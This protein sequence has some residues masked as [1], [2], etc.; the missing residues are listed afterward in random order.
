MKIA[1]KFL[2]ILIV[3][4]C[5][6]TA[7]A[8]DAMSFDGDLPVFKWVQLKSFPEMRVPIYKSEGTIGPGVLF[9]HG[10]SSS[11]RAFHKQIYSQFGRKYKMFFMD[12]PGHGLASKVDLSEAMPTLPNS[13][14]PA[15]FKAYQEGVPEAVGLVANDPDVQAKVV[16]GWSLGGH[17]AIKA[18]GLSYLPKVQGIF[19][20]GTAPATRYSPIQASSFL[21][22]GVTD[23][24][25]M[26]ILPSFGLSF[27]LNPLKENLFTLD[28][29][30]TDPMPWYSPRMFSFYPSRGYAYMT[31][32]FDPNGSFN[33]PIPDFVLQDGFE[34]SDDRFRTSLAVMALEID[35]RRKGEPTELELLERMGEQKVTLGVALGERDM[36]IN[37]AY[38]QELKEKGYLST[39]WQNEIKMIK[40]S[41][42]AS[43]LEQPEAFNKMVEEFILDVVGQN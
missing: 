9:I 31:A 41:G 29:K 24:L 42:H 19:V 7:S 20:Y 8:E 34:R 30:F 37:P 39:L 5:Q 16:V 13:E 3:L 17:V 14:L 38:L 12:L 35:D 25:G 10:N 33:R 32:F 43:Q 27:K 2:L 23:Q 26:S 4:L 15:G 21:K 6:F 40:N 1:N 18:F 22:F 11:S 28:A 36:F